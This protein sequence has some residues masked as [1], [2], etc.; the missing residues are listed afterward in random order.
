MGPPMVQA[1]ELEEKPAFSSGWGDRF[2]G[3]G[4]MGLPFSSGH[5]LSFRRMTG[6]SVGPPFTTVWHRDPAGVW[7]V[8][9]DQEPEVTC[10]RYFGSAIDRVIHGPIDLNWE[11]PMQ[12]SVRVPEARLEWAARLS[13]DLRTRTVTAL[14]GVLPSFA[15]GSAPVMSV[16]GQVASRFLGIGAMNLSGHA[17]NGQRYL[18]APKRF[19]R[20]DASAAVLEGVELGDIK[21]LPKQARVGSVRVPNGGIF[22][23]G[24]AQFEAFD[25]GRHSRATTRWTQDGYASIGGHLPSQE[26]PPIRGFPSTPSPTPH[27][28]ETGGID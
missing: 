20:V 24:E 3:Y 2:R 9:V 26:V 10:T 23:I 8:Y 18:A 4:V 7:T 13:K 14:G 11:G 1:Q 27:P 28:P 15:W 6:S 25:P 21:K 16:L 22:A 17:P 19:W 12:V 5:L